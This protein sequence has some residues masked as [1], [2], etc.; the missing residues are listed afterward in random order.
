MPQVSSFIIS[1]LFED[2]PF[3]ILLGDN[4]LVSFFQDFFP[5]L[6]VFWTLI[7]ICLEVNFFR[8]ILS[9]I[10][11]VSSICRW[12]LSLKLGSFQPLFLWIFSTPALF[13]F[14]ALLS[15]STN[16]RSLVIVPHVPQA[17]LT[18]PVFSLLF[19]WVISVLSSGWLIHS[20]VMSF[21]HWVV[22]FS[23]KVSSWFFFVSFIFLLRLSI[24]FYVSSMS[25]NCSSKHFMKAAFK[26]LLDNPSFGVM[27]L[28]VFSHL[29]SDFPLFLAWE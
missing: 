26:S 5:L 14:S 1:F 27:S 13:S 19:Y 20:H 15:N 6:L 25:I 12:W 10:F 3:A 24:F 9:G 29:S 11:S 8:F 18:S 21:S 2:L 16:V 22:F 23:S 28:V 4:L 17:P 7:T